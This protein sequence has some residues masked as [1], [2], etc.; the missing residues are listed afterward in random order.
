MAVLTVA[1]IDDLVKDRAQINVSVDSPISAA[2]L[3]R[4]ENE[5]YAD[6]WEIFGG[7]IKSVAHATAWSVSPT[8][9]A[10][11]KLVGILTDINEP[12]RMWQTATSGSVGGL[13]GEHLLVR[14]DLAE[15]QA[16]RARGSALG[17]YAASKLVALTPMATTTAADVNKIR[18][19]IWPGVASV[20]YPLEYTPQF[21]P[22]VNSTDVPDVNDLA[23]R[24]LALWAALKIV[25]A[26]G[27]HEFAPGLTADISQRT[28]AGLERKLAA[29]L[30]GDQDSS[31][32][33]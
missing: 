5:A 8:A 18:A 6:I 29:L 3:L 4:F 11:G 9:D 17:T 1:Q 23:S 14:T 2:E 31:R 28:Q 30:S 22:L 27:R 7:S 15:I 25:V 12:L 19:D 20:Y 10:T 26:L 33:N 24:D 16:L 21:T 13:A 32:S